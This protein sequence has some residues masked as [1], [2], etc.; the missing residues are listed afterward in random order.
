MSKTSPTEVSSTDR[1]AINVFRSPS[2]LYGFWRTPTLN[3]THKSYWVFHAIPYHSIE[4]SIPAL[5]KMS[6]ASQSA[7]D[8]T[9]DHASTQIMTSRNGLT[10]AE[11]RGLVYMHGKKQSHTVANFFTRVVASFSSEKY[12]GFVFEISLADHNDDRK[13]EVALTMAQLNDSNVIKSILQD[14]CDEMIWYRVPKD[15]PGS[16][17][18]ATYMFQQ[19]R[20]YNAS[21]DKVSKKVALQYPGWQVDGVFVVSDAIQINTKEEKLL[22]NREKYV[23]Y[24]STKS[25][26]EAKQRRLPH[27]LQPFSSKALA[28]L[29]GAFKQFLGNNYPAACL[30][31]GGV[32]MATGHERITSVYGSC[33]VIILSGDTETGKTTVLRIFSREAIILFQTPS[34]QLKPKERRRCE[35]ELRKATKEGSKG[36]LEVLGSVERFFS[37]VGQELLDDMLRRAGQEDDMELVWQYVEDTVAPLIKRIYEESSSAMKLSE[38]V[39]EISGDVNVWETLTKK[40]TTFTPREVSYVCRKMKVKGVDCICLSL[41]FLNGAL[42][43]PNDKTCIQQMESA[44]GNHVQLTPYKTR[45]RFLSP[46]SDED[47]FKVSYVCRKMKVKGVDCICLSLNFLNGAL[48]SPNDKTCIQQMESG[49]GNHVQ[50]TP[51]KTRQRFLSPESDEDHFKIIKGV[52]VVGRTHYLRALALPEHLLPSSL[53]R[54]AEGIQVSDECEDDTPAVTINQGAEDNIETDGAPAV[55]INQAQEDN[56]ETG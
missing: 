29:I 52:D 20:T 50:L 7:E 16:V 54:T 26:K 13:W 42:G 32:A 41:N 1:D 12:S 47:H 51:Y 10:E 24:R 21:E 11:N 19:T 39:Q 14:H 18:L 55:T 9:E 37:Q 34:P 4:Y 27:F 8:I 30:A 44:I 49:I 40:M 2:H 45:Q 15:A 22:E 6:Q 36:F 33:P 53:K 17:D 46:E 3:V 28:D 5:S 23:L 56:I 48:G 25:G 35:S 43:S 38:R 31:V